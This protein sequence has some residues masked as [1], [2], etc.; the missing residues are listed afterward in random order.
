MQSCCQKCCTLNCQKCCRSICRLQL[1]SEM[2]Q[3]LG[4]Q[5]LKQTSIQRNYSPQAHLNQSNE[6]WSYQQTAKNFFESGAE[7]HKLWIAHFKDSNNHNETD[8]VED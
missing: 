5:K 4:Y 6:N 2:A 1:L 7:M 3:S 8:N